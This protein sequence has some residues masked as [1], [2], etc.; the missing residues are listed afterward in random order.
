M[1]PSR[2]MRYPT[3]GGSHQV[4]MWPMG[5]TSWASVPHLERF[6]DTGTLDLEVAQWVVRSQPEAPVRETNLFGRPVSAIPSDAAR[7]AASP[8]PAYL[9]SHHRSP[10]QN[11]PIKPSS[12]LTS[13]FAPTPLRTRA[14]IGLPHPF[15][16]VRLLMLAFLY[17]F[18][19]VLFCFY[20]VCVVD[21]PTVLLKGWLLSRHVISETL[22]AP[23]TT[24]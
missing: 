7:D 11:I 16:F 9:S 21:V 14:L 24:S 20:L 8:L 2:S 19:F 17:C 3:L 10:F 15:M 6:L 4:K 5:L 23:P 12:R 22:S 18:F 1:T 13:D